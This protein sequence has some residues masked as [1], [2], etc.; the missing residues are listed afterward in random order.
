MPAAAVSK[1]QKWRVYAYH[2]AALAVHALLEVGYGTI[3]D[4]DAST[5]LFEDAFLF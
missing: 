1:R 2:K 4:V 3:F 5:E